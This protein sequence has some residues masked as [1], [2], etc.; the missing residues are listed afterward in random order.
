MNDEQ[1][2]TLTETAALCRCSVQTIRN[3]RDKRAFP[4]PV[5]VNYSQAAVLKWC[6]EN[7]VQVT[8]IQGV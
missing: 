5:G 1:F 2:L 8:K 3:W 4:E 6:R 7:G